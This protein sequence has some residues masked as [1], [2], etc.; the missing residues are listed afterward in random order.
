[1]PTST[2]LPVLEMD[3]T[4]TP[5]PVNPL[6]AKGVGEAGTVAAP[7]AVVNAVVDALAPFGIAHIDMPLWPE[8]VWQAIQRA[9]SHKP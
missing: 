6:G 1:M 5:T 7:L 4:E 3:R 8:K 9:G 2:V